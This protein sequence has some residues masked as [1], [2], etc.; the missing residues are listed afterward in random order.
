MEIFIDTADL[1]EI[2]SAAALS[3][4]DGVTTN[5][6][7]LSKQDLPPKKIIMAINEIVDGKVWYQV[8]SETT[9][10]MINEALE[11]ASLIKKPVIKLPMGIEGLN[12]CHALAK[13]RIETN[14]TL[15]FSVSQALLAAK[16]GASYI[17]PYVGRVNDTGWSG[18]QLIKEIVHVFEIQQYQ[19]KV[20]GAS[21]RGTHD[22]VEMAMMG[23]KAVTMPYKVFTGLLEHPM[24]GI[25][26]SQFDHDWKEYQDRL[27]NL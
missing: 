19:T 15:I 6:T 13:Q 12:A 8:S 27:K 18:Y 11:M 1:H 22:I 2:K 16:A 10:E 7:I 26:R 25:G 3:I 24:T 23:A 5:P 4:L 20:I 9:Q 17:S 14:M 21:L